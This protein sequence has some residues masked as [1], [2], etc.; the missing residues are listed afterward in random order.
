MMEGI[1]FYLFAIKLFGGHG[2][3][4]KQ[5]IQPNQNQSSVVEADITV[6]A[7]ALGIVVFLVENL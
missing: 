6:K 3:T 4:Y 5:Y 2:F 7:C 1:F